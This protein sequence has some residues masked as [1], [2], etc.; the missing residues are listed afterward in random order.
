MTVYGAGGYQRYDTWML[1]ALGVASGTTDEVTVASWPL[2][3]EIVPGMFVELH[4]HWHLTQVPA[5][6]ETFTVRI[7]AVGGD[8]DP[9]TILDSGPIEPAYGTHHVGPTYARIAWMTNK[10]ADHDPDTFMAMTAYLE[11][12]WGDGSAASQADSVQGRVIE[13]VVTNSGDVFDW[14]DVVS[15]DVTAQWSTATGSQA[16]TDK[17]FVEAGVA[18][19]IEPVA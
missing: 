15:L 14:R 17:F 10:D 2:P 7:R 12:L 8:P 18:H 13:N 19:L 4:K 11:C 6:P 16:V 1:D 5:A 3:W 9:Y